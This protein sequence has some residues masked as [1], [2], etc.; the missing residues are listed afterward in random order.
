MQRSNTD[1]SLFKTEDNV[2]VPNSTYLFQLFIFGDLHKL[3]MIFNQKSFIARKLQFLNQQSD[4]SNL[5][6]SL[7]KFHGTFSMF[8]R[9]QYTVSRIKNTN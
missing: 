1:K 3:T 5:R 8:I 4:K 9:D 2:L 6:N 7:Q